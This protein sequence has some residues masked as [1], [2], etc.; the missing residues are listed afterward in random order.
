MA[1]HEAEAFRRTAGIVRLAHGARP[2]QLNSI[3]TIASGPAFEVRFSPA[4]AV[5]A[6]LA[7]EELSQSLADELGSDVKSARVAWTPMHV[8]PDRVVTIRRS[9][10]VPHV[11]AVRPTPPLP[12]T[13]PAAPAPAAPTADVQSSSEAPAPPDPP[14]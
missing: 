14:A 4:P 11:R 2:T 6:D 9:L 10:T 13:P 8:Q 7:D 5:D 1:L 12:P 3:A